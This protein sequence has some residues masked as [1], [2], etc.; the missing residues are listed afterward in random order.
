MLQMPLLFFFLLLLD[1]YRSYMFDL[2]HA[3]GH[4]TVIHLLFNCSRKLVAKFALSEQR[5]CVDETM[6]ITWYWHLANWDLTASDNAP[7][8]VLRGMWRTRIM[9]MIDITIAE[10]DQTDRAKIY[11]EQYNIS[12]KK[13]RRTKDKASNLYLLTGDQLDNLNEKKSLIRSIITGK[14]I[15]SGKTNV[16]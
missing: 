11:S 13:T 6:R 8:A 5:I 3:Y 4:T 16:V 7:L 1:R 14:K 12:R 15:T 10:G 2:Q 9:F